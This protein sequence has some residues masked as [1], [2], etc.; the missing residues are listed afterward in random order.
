MST[1]KNISEIAQNLG[2]MESDLEFYGPYKAKIKYDTILEKVK[3]KKGKLIL[4]SAITPTPAGEGKTTTAIGL[5]IGL[6]RIGKKSI[7]T[8]REPSMGPLFGM[9]GG[10]TG[11]GKTIVEPTNDINLHFTGDIHAIGAA[12]N[13]ISAVLDNHIFRKKEPMVDPRRIQWNRVIDMN[14]RALRDIVTGLG[15]KRNGFPTENNFS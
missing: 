14:D 3:G 11:G 1:I 10:A 8:L 6:N 5:S 9:K 4:V 13:L 15:G 12:H 2:L 7:V